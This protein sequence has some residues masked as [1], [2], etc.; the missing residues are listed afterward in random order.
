LGLKSRL[1]LL[2]EFTFFIADGERAKVCHS[3]GNV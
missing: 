1:Q 3:A 2:V